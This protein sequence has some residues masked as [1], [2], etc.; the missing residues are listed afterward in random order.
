MPSV[1]AVTFAIQLFS[2][3]VEPPQ[4]EMVIMFEDL[5]KL[6]ILMRSILPV[7]FESQLNPTQS[8]K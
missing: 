3:I 1:G 2:S 4:T 6:R 8:K 7:V 5:R